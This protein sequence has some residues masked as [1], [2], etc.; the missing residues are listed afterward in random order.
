VYNPRLVN[1]KT[2]EIKIRKITM[3]MIGVGMGIPGIKPPILDSSGLETV[4][5]APP[6]IQ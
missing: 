2:S 3:I 1:L 4:G 6:F 5:V